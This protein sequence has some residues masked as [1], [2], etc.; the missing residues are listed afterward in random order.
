MAASSYLHLAS[1]YD[2]PVTV[3]E[4]SPIGEA[5]GK[6]SDDSIEPSAK[7]REYIRQNLSSRAVIALGGN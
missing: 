2:A 1:S 7:L 3:V 5:G 6:N 4:K